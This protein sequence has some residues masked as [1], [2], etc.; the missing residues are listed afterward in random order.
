MTPAQ[1]KIYQPGDED[2]DGPHPSILVR[3]R[4]KGKGAPP[5]RKPLLPEAVAA[6]RFAI[7][8][9]AL[10]VKF[11]TSSMRKAFLRARDA[12]EAELKAINPKVDLADMRLY[13]LRH[14]LGSLYFKATKS[15][16][17][18]GALLDHTHERTTYRY[19]LSEIPPHLQIASDAAQAILA[20]LPAD[21]A[22]AAA[23]KPATTLRR[24]K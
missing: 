21:V 20:A 2:L 4:R 9:G 7:A 18:T 22:P 3:G 11:S 19:A 12:A 6:I 5:R 14:C 16:S 17:V 15:L 10:G 8:V 24:V 1:M 13:D 23:V